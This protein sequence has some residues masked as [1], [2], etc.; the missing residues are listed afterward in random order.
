MT[1]HA[2]FTKHTFKTNTLFNPAFKGFF[3]RLKDHRTDNESACTNHRVLKK[4]EEMQKVIQA[5]FKATEKDLIEKYAKRNADGSLFVPEKDPE[6]AQA[7]MF[8]DQSVAVE[9]GKQEEFLDAMKKHAEEFGSVERT[10]E[11]QPLTASSL[12]GFSVSPAEIEALQSLMVL[13]KPDLP[14]VL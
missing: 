9:D 3:E 7:A 14:H 6:D 4:V 10:I 12:K 8:K 13:D 11:V 2:H 1:A 5:E